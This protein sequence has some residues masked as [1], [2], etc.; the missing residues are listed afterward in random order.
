MSDATDTPN[1]VEQALTALTDVLREVYGPKVGFVMGFTIGKPADAVRFSNI[2]LA[3]QRAILIALLEELPAET[4][5]S[6]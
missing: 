2:C 5:H 6:H 1:R 4:K 3:C